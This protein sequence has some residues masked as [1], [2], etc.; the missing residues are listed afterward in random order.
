M[1]GRMPFGLKAHHTKLMKESSLALEEMTCILIYTERESRE[2]KTD[3]LICAQQ[4]N[5]GSFVWSAL[6]IE[7]SYRL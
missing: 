3:G 4:G 2:Y 7:T 1:A 6:N 5:I